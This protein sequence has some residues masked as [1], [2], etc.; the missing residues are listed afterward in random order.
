M[1]GH[2]DGRK[3]GRR[4]TRLAIV[5][6]ALATLPVQFAQA[7]YYEGPRGD[8][9]GPPPGY[10]DRDYDRGPRPRPRRMA[11]E[12]VG[13]NCAAVQEG[14]TGP[15]PYSCPLPGPRPIDAHC[16]CDLP[17]APFSPPQTAVGRVVR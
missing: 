6:L 16:F 13:L 12:P 9:R 14:I 3:D 2:R 11:R 7:Q 8:G 4:S 5:A 15:K 10:D 17:I 1:C